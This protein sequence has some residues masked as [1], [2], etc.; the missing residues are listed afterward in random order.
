MFTKQKTK[1]SSSFTH[2]LNGFSVK[3]DGCYEQIF[4]REELSSKNMREKDAH[5]NVKVEKDW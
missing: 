2:K 1:E 4:G 3:E 5:N